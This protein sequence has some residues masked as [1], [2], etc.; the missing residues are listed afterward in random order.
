MFACLLPTSSPWGKILHQSF[1]LRSLTPAGQQ[2]LNII[3]WKQA[4]TQA[5]CI[6]TN[7]FKCWHGVPYFDHF[8]YFSQSLNETLSGT[9]S[10]KLLLVKVG[11]QKS[12]G[13]SPQD[14]LSLLESSHHLYCCLCPVMS[15]MTQNIMYDFCIINTRDH[16]LP[17]SAFIMTGIKFVDDYEGMTLG[18]NL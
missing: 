3:S 11:T 5:N 18:N 6:F 7:S 13:A 1:S 15:C 12:Q 14:V 10:Q 9:F 4:S 16:L 2:V 17:Y 8:Y